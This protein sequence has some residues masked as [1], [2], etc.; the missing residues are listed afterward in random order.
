MA[1]RPFTLSEIEKW[2]SLHPVEKA[3]WDDLSRFS[4]FRTPIVLKVIWTVSYVSIFMLIS[5]YKTGWVPY[6]TWSEETFIQLIKLTAWAL[7]PLFFSFAWQYYVTHLSRKFF[8]EFYLPP[9][10]LENKYIKRLIK[11]RVKGIPPSS[12]LFKLLNSSLEY[13]SVLISEDGLIKPEDSWVSWLGGP[14]RLIILDGVALYLERGN[15]FSRV[16]GSGVVFLDR[17]E[18]VRAVV[19]LTPQKKDVD[20]NASTKDGIPIS[21]TAH[22]V[23][24]AGLNPIAQSIEDKRLYPLDP[25]AVKNLVERT[26]LKYK[27]NGEFEESHWYD[28][29]WGQVSG[30]LMKYITCHNLDEFFVFDADKENTLSDLIQKKLIDEVKPKLEAFGVRLWELQIKEIKQPEEVDKQRLQNWE[31]ERLGRATVI[32]GQT[33]ANQFRMIQTARAI[34]QRDLILTIAEGLDKMDQEHLEESLLLSLS[35]ILDKSL[36][37]PSTRSLITSD[38][39]TTLENLKKYL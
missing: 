5:L 24:Q 31:A 34:A 23:F 38:A 32:E 15:K 4:S 22:I 39:L 37:D 18:T 13:P 28:A 27:D 9:S 6:F 19:Q 26:A 14:A 8:H 30:P 3:H 12:S 29:V 2:Q 35:A 33:K 11:N 16:V 7:I 10:E 36:S 21:V 1:I 20:L 17:F 25:L